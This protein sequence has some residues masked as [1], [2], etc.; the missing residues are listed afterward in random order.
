LWLVL[1]VLT[2]G[3][4]ALPERPVAG[5]ASGT[6]PAVYAVED[7]GSLAEG[8]SSVAWG[9]NE[10]GDVVGWSAG[11]DGP[12]AFLYTDAG[13]LAPLPAPPNRPVTLA[14]DI[15]ENGD[16][17]GA[18]GIGGVDLGS[19]VLWTG[20]TVRDLGALGD[21]GFSEAWSI[22]NSGEVVGW[23]SA[24][25]GGPGSHAFLYTASAG[26]TDLDPASDTSRATA[27]NDAGQVTGYRTAP[28]GFHAFRW[29]SGLFDDLGV[30]PGFAYSSGWAISSTGR[31]AGSSSSASGNS[32]RLF[33]ASEGGGLENLGGAGEHNWA[34]GINTGGDVVGAGRISS[35]R[36]VLFSDTADLQDLNNLIDPASGWVLL[37]AHAINDAGQIA[38]YGL[39]IRTGWTHALRLS[40]TEELPIH[41]VR[42]T[43]IRLRAHPQRRGHRITG[44]VLVR[45]EAGAAVTG[46]AVSVEWAHPAGR[47]ARAVAGTSDRGVAVFEATGGRGR[48]TLTVT[49][50]QHPAYRMDRDGS[51]LS[52]SIVVGRLT[53]TDIPA[54]YREVDARQ[55]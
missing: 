28:G 21:G 5:A 11:S 32:E 12:R 38:A 33:R 36:A 23:S 48:H 41:L 52:R 42:S 30:L 29:Q 26:M 24:P 27:I 19:A 47:S 15:N 9:I 34:L 13:G 18:A 54:D 55:P 7:L 37:A 4:A 49:G 43:R 53:A 16:I 20:G 6:G 31:V 14:R 35:R 2:A 50:I 22:N 25:G 51:V 10:R 3:S 45:D 8:W 46:A 1:T 40:P 39:N 17:A 44:R